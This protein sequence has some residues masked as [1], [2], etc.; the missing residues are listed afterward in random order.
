VQISGVSKGLGAEKA[1][2]KPGDIIVGINGKVITDDDSLKANLKIYK[3]GNVVDVKVKRDDKELDLKITLSPKPLSQG[4]I[5]NKMGSE[6]S[7]VKTGFPVVLQHDSIVKP[8]ECGGPLVDL[9]GKGIG[10]NL[11][12]VGRTE[13]HAIPTEAL[14]PLLDEMIAGKHPPKGV[15]KVQ[16]PPK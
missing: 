3:P 16:A 7:K 10:I 2:M 1:G 14:L 8:K 5:Q 11:A 9:E 4:E 15:E 13:S 12:R 6:L